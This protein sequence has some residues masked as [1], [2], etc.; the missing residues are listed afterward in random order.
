ML[1]PTEIL[2]RTNLVDDSVALGELA[3]GLKQAVKGRFMEDAY[4]AVDINP[5]R[6]TEGGFAD[7]KANNMDNIISY[8]KSRLEAP[9]PDVDPPPGGHHLELVICVCMYSEDKRML[10]DTMKGIEDNV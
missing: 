6:I 8:L 7:I 3:Q 9:G 4:D 2:L 5:F 1:R 10:K